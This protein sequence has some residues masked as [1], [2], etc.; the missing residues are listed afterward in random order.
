VPAL[1]GQDRQR[2]HQHEAEAPL[3]Q[4]QQNVT[5]FEVEVL[6]TDQ[7]ARLLRPLMS[8]DADI[9]TET[10]D[11]ALVIP[12]AALVFEGDAVLVDHVV[13]ASAPTLERRPVKVGIVAG[14]KAQILDGIAAGDEV[15]LR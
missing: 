7:D 1:L 12:E 2:R 10:V 6:V 5:Y 15:R 9:V 3:G 13:R 4:R 14:N 11:D 8:A